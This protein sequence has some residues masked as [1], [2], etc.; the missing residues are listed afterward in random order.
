MQELAA[1]HSG[2]R[3]LEELPGRTP[4]VSIASE[5][6]GPGKSAGNGQVFIGNR[7]HG[8]VN[9]EVNEG[10][11][12]TSV[13]TARSSVRLQVCELETRGFRLRER[14]RRGLPG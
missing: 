11:G 8:Q 4:A 7:V 2:K 3:V 5:G 12:V 1:F 6:D 13:Q 9:S 10:P 14:H